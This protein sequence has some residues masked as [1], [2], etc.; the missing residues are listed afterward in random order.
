EWLFPGKDLSEHL[1]PSAAWRAV[2]KYAWRARMPGLKPHVLRHT[3]ATNM[4]RGGADIV[5]A[6]EIL[7]HARLD[8]TRIYTRPSM[9]DMAR[10]LERGEA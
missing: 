4:L 1:S 7:G 6:A 8:A 10:A 3:C 9:A 2:K 5:T